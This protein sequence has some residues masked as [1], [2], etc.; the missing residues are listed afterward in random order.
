MLRVGQRDPG[1]GKPPVEHRPVY[2]TC[3]TCGQRYPLGDQPPE[4][5]GVGE[6]KEHQ[7][8]PVRVSWPNVP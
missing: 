1:P 3:R 4:C 2:M 5:D 6:G 8:C 7:P